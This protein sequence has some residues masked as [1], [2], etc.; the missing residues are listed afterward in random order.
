MKFIFYY[1]LS[2]KT[3]FTA[4]C[5]NTKNFGISFKKKITQ[6]ILNQMIMNRLPYNIC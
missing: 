3:D 4:Y 2:Y 6:T 5:P 1:K